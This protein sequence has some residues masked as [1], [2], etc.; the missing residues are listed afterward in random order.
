[1]M[2]IIMNMFLN[3]RDYRISSVIVFFLFL[4][5]PISAQHL[6]GKWKFSKETILEMGLG[7]SEIKG[8]CNFKR[9][10]M[11]TVV[12]KGRSLLGY[13]FWKN[14]TMYAK[15]KGKYVLNDG[16]ITTTLS[17][18]DIKVDVEP[19][20]EHP[21]IDPEQSEKNYRTTWDSKTVMYDA[22][23]LKCDVQEQTI[24]EKMYSFWTC[25]NLPVSY[26]GNSYLNVGDMIKLQK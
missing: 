15:L 7:Y 5:Q 17:I 13:Y 1:M 2:E 9:N 19:E 16:K 14:R 6:E 18:K 22:A 25:D 26:A 20:I 3:F 21:S 8:K 4:F 10:G 24:R 23:K 11:F 12:I